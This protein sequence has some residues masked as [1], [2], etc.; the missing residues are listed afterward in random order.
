MFLEINEFIIEWMTPGLAKCE[1]QKNG[2]KIET[3][4]RLTASASAFLGNKST[5]Q[6]ERC[7]GWEPKGVDLL[8]LGV[9]VQW[10][11]LHNP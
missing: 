10:Q 7:C 9:W 1:A 5:Q 2:K 11:A 8:T 6:K 3:A 4:R